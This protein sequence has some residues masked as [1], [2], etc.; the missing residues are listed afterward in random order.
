M[1]LA[2][3]GLLPPGTRAFVVIYDES[4]LP[5]VGILEIVDQQVVVDDVTVE[6][7]AR[8]V[9]LSNE[10]ADRLAAVFPNHVD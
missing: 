7:R 8:F 3:S 6:L 4:H 9:H 2:T 1:V 10:N 5:V